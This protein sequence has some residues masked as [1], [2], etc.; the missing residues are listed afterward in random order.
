M[1]CAASIRF[2]RAALDLLLALFRGLAA[3]AC[4]GDGSIDFSESRAKWFRCIFRVTF[5]RSRS[6]RERLGRQRH[7]RIRPALDFTP[8]SATVGQV[9][10]GEVAGGGQL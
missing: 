7:D 6:G 3:D 10:F 9:A 5:A 2:V 8:Q 4:Q 1:V